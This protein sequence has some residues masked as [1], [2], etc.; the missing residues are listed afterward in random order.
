MATHSSILAWRIPWAENPGVLQSM[1][2]QT[3]RHGRVTNTGTHMHARTHTHTHTH[4]GLIPLYMAKVKRL[5]PLFMGGKE[6]T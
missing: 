6:G 5:I 1:G 4:T 3:V 2:L